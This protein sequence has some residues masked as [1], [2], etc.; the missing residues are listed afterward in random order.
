VTSLFSACLLII[1]FK[2]KLNFGFWNGTSLKTSLVNRKKMKE[3]NAKIL[4]RK[5]KIEKI[6]QKETMGFM[7]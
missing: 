2:L 7:D 3:I 1:N 5:S 6:L 4:T